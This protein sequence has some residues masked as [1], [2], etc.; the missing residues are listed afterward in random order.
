MVVDEKQIFN[1]W[2]TNGR[3][4]DILNA[5]SIYISILKELEEENPNEKWGSYPNSMAQYKFYVK[6]LSASPDVF[7]E[8]KKYDEFMELIEE[9]NDAFLNK[10]EDW[11]NDNSNDKVFKLL[12][13]AI[14]ARARHYTSN[15]VRMGF[16]TNNRKITPSGM[17][18]HKNVI[19]RD[20]IEKILPLSNTNI[21]LLR[22]MM[23]LRVFSKKNNNK[24]YS[25][26]PFY[27][28]LYLLLKEDNVDK[29][30]FIKIIQGANPY[31]DYHKRDILLCDDFSNE[32]KEHILM[33][34]DIKVPA[35]FSNFE[36]ISNEVF[37]K[38]I[39][40]RKSGKTE[41]AYYDFYFAM[42]SYNL[43]QSDDNYERIKEVYL[44]YK[45]KIKK[46]FTC[47]KSLFD[48]GTNGVYNHAMFVAK[49]QNNPFIKHVK[50]NEY[51]YTAYES[52]K[53]VDTL[54][55]YSDTTMRMLGATGII[56]TSKP[57][58]EL[59][60]KNI[61]KEFFPIQLVKQRIFMIVDE[62]D[63]HNYE[64]VEDSYFGNVQTISDI[65]GINEKFI[66]S[67]LIH[68]QE[69]YCVDDLNGLIKELDNQ[70]NSNFN[71][72]IKENYPLTKVKELLALFS[73]RAN[74]SKLKK[75]VSE[76]ADVPTIYEYIVGI[77]WYY[78]SNK[79]FNLYD[80]FNLTL[81][82]DF[83]P[84][85]HAGG[86]QGDIV[87]DYD[88][89]SIMIEVTLM[90]KAAQ[91]RGEWEPVLRHSI[92]NKVGKYPKES[93][94]F[95]IADELDYNTINIWRAVAAVPLESTTTKEKV[96][97]VV[98][99]PFSNQEICSFLNKNIKSI[100]I[101]SEVKKS[102]LTIPQITD[103]NWRKNILEK[104]E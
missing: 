56:R 101:I 33:N 74:D 3:R 8:H 53:Y 86:G 87:I 61:L 45:D 12:D 99:M 44:K 19:D 100:D 29:D 95:F 18:F 91:K 27:M 102:Y 104:F 79:D 26:S 92:N 54:Y 69:I 82:A 1:L 55:E 43:N 67:K 36:M 77:A 40:N 2:N 75:E 72:F 24:R 50:F 80:C 48:F 22:Q 21:L 47:G 23:K 5:L 58:I 51:F 63:Y 7:Q 96:N 14:E 78:L 28:A 11:I 25:Y 35:D 65:F 15:L 103:D 6:A 30:S 66:N 20:L 97:G 64:C 46:A 16:A 85:M 94:T 37:S 13:E 84:E 34:I 93:F 42:Y 83:A 88:D 10:N 49:N 73:N 41:Q 4:S 32:I 31:L 9:H 71:R 90:N 39:K 57:L 17:S 98:I 60:F 81:N 38:Y 59:A 76:S 70:I 62:E 68:L 52:S 89:K